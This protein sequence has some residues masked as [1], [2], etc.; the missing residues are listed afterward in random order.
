MWNQK[1]C[2]SALIFMLARQILFSASQYLKRWRFC[3]IRKTSL[4]W[5]LV[6]QEVLSYYVAFCC[7][8]RLVTLSSQLSL[9][10]EPLTEFD[11]HSRFDEKLSTYASNILNVKCTSGKKIFAVLQTKRSL[12]RREEEKSCKFLH[13]VCY[14]FQISKF[15]IYIY[16]AIVSFQSTGNILQPNRRLWGKNGKRR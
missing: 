5:T 6:L 4:W 1:N 16:I 14:L 15:Y 7:C 12:A 9:E 11:I 3:W 2:K 13:S 8:N 10:F